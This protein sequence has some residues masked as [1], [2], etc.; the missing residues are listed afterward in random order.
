MALRLREFLVDEGGSVTMEFMV[1]LPLLVAWLVGSFVMFDMFWSYSQAEKATYVIGDLV[2]RVDA[3]SDSIFD[4]YAV[5]YGLMTPRAPGPTDL[6][7]STVAFEDGN[8]VLRWSHVT[9]GV[10]GAASTGTMPLTDATLPLAILPT[11]AEFDS[12][13]L[14]EAF[15]PFVPIAGWFGLEP[16]TM[17][18]QVTLRPRFVREISYAGGGA[19][20]T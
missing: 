17:A 7:I 1:A 4:E 8:Y 9:H 11:L 5:V 12:V 18:N 2:S 10:A 6:R 3:V 13:V 20:G 14:V 16:F 19:A 15:T